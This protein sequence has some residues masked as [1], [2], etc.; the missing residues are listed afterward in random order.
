MSR[1]WKTGSK[2][3]RLSLH[4]HAAQS[5]FSIT[6][7]CVYLTLACNDTARVQN[8]GLSTFISCETSGGTTPLIWWWICWICWRSGGS[9]VGSVLQ[10]SYL[11]TFLHRGWNKERHFL[12]PSVSPKPWPQLRLCYP[13]LYFYHY[14]VCSLGQVSTKFFLGFFFFLLLLFFHLGVPGFSHPFTI[15][16]AW[17]LFD[18]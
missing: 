5:Q 17:G 9:P 3:P 6:R 14:T 13:H 8:S 12:A 1:S 10:L 2:H 16:D 15:A 18:Y 4:M 11:D 7:T